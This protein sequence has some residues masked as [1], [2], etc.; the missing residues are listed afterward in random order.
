MCLHSPAGKSRSW[1]GAG[2]RGRAFP[3]HQPGMDLLLLPWHH[4]PC[5][6][7]TILALVPQSLPW[8]HNSILL[9][10]SQASADPKS[11][12][13]AQHKGFDPTR[14]R[15]ITSVCSS[16]SQKPGAVL[17]VSRNQKLSNVPTLP[18]S[19]L[20]NLALF[21]L[22]FPLFLSPGASQETSRWC[23]PADRW[24]GNEEEQR[25]V[26]TAS[27]ALLICN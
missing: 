14:A 16:A 5:L 20:G 23:L 24:R 22:C 6:G 4:N 1:E 18:G 19:S 8:Y 26:T 2:D 27:L 10:L 13:S 3:P 21:S 7:T 11:P 25:G 9:C 12:F 15:I 17:S